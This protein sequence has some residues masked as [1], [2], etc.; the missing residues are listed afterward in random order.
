MLL[1]VRATNNKTRENIVLPMQH[2]EK[3]DTISMRLNINISTTGKIWHKFKEKN[4]KDNK[5]TIN[6]N[7]KGVS[8]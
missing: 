3:H 4:K 7:S 8:I 6:E 5:E 2:K 1:A